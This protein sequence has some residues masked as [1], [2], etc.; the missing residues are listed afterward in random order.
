MDCTKLKR[1]CHSTTLLLVRLVINS[2]GQGSASNNWE[3][4]NGWCVFSIAH[5]STSSKVVTL[6]CFSH[7]VF[8]TTVKR[9]EITFNQLLC[10]IGVVLLKKI[11]LCLNQSKRALMTKSIQLALGASGVVSSEV[12][13]VFDLPNEVNLSEAIKVIVQ[14][15]IGVATLVSMFKK[16]K[17]KIN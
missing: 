4:F 3:L 5:P 15:V 9:F 6:L 14:I 11:Y 16:P 17:E 2:S 12:V 7:Q 1:I 10:G 8:L 13:S